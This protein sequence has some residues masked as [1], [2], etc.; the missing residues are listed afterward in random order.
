MTQVQ[1]WL[2]TGIGGSRIDFVAG[3]LGCLPGFINNNWSIDPNTGQSIGEMRLFKILDQEPLTL[4]EHLKNIGNLEISDAPT[5]KI[6]GSLHGFKIQT[7][8]NDTDNVVIIYIRVSE[9]SYTKIGWEYC[10]KTLLTRQHIGQIGRTSSVAEVEQSL[11]YYKN[12]KLRLKPHPKAIILDYDKLFVQGGSRYLADTLGLV[13]AD[14]LHD[15][16]DAM[17]E[18]ADSPLEVEALGKV[19]RYSDYFC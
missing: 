11:D 10:V 7:Q 19:W 5:L 3:W 2:V 12:F 14:R 6:C 13:A 18:W 9:K 15:Y 8:I 4:A 16:Y 1:P 17:L